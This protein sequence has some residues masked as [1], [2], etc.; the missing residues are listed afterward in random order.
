MCIRKKSDLIGR[1]WRNC[2]TC[3]ALLSADK[4]LSKSH[5]G[6]RLLVN[7]SN[8][9]TLSYTVKIW[10]IEK[11]RASG[12]KSNP[13]WNQANNRQQSMTNL[14]Q[15][16]FPSWR[17]HS[18]SDTM[19]RLLIE[20]LLWWTKPDRPRLNR[21]WLE[22]ATATSTFMDPPRVYLPATS[23]S[24]ITDNATNR[25]TRCRW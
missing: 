9:D 3:F 12:S 23:E 24:K 19:T 13:K 18:G 2:Q 14:A 21:F 20:Q 10:F 4:L 17:S 8:S 25:H 6:W 5:D 11:S 1:S 22:L 15:L 7:T 16:H